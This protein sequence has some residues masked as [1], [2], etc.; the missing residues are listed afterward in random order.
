M[1]YM[2]AYRQMY[3]ASSM[4]GYRVQAQQGHQ[5]PAMWSQAQ[6]LALYQQNPQRAAAVMMGH[7]P[8]HASKQTEPKPRL[9]K[10]EVEVLEREFAKNQKPNSSVKRDLAEKMGVEVPRINNWFQ[11][12]RAKEKQMKKAREFEAQQAKDRDSVESKS[13]SE[14]GNQSSDTEGLDLDDTHASLTVSTAFFQ[15]RATVQF[16]NDNDDG[17]GDDN[18][19]TN[20]D[21][22]DDDDENE[23]GDTEDVDNHLDT[24]HSSHHRTLEPISTTIEVQSPRGS[25]SDG[26]VHDD[27][28]SDIPHAQFNTDFAISSWTLDAMNMQGLRETT[29]STTTSDEE[30]GYTFGPLGAP[31]FKAE[32]AIKTPPGT[33]LR[34]HEPMFPQALD[35]AWGFAQQQDEPLPTPSLCSH[36]SELDFSVAPSLPAY[37]ASQ[38]V[39]PSF[40]SAAIG[41]TYGGFLGHHGLPGTEYTFPDAYA[42]EVPTLS[43]PSLPKLKQFQFAQNVTPQDFAVEK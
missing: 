34:F 1:E 17:G 3:P 12:R 28:I 19:N 23:N 41:P 6:L 42:V 2:D 43:S 21:D 4:Q 15:S 36:G 25:D 33:P 20:D 39:T 5:F 13:D 7:S 38:P 29:V 18:D 35:Q 8:I 32:Q 14:G 24:G 37:V 9:A 26:F 16:D 31:F 22:D 30:Q 27:M 11:N 10:D 40:P